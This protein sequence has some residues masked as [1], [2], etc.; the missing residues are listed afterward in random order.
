MVASLI[1]WGIQ[2]FVNGFW[3][4]ILP[5]VANIA[6]ISAVV[7]MFSVP[8]IPV[9]VGAIIR[10]TVVSTVFVIISVIILEKIHQET[11]LP[12]ALRN[13][14]K[15]RGVEL[16]DGDAVMINVNIKRGLMFKEGNDETTSDNE[17]E[18]PSGNEGDDN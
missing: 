2:K 9:D 7:D 14:L 13:E 6:L 18:I 4:L 11:E 16:E 15:R 5:V 1:G 8:G 17:N 12:E 10:H 3:G